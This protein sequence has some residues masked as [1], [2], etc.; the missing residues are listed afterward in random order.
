MSTKDGPLLLSLASLALGACAPEILPATGAQRQE[1]FHSEI[2]DDDYVLRIRTP[3]DMEADPGATH[4]LVVQLDP[5]YAGL[6]EHEI[7]VGLVSQHAADG[8]WPEA[9]VVGVD[10]PDP[11]TRERDY[12]PETPPDPEFEGE[13]A[14]RFHRVLQD[15]ILPHLE[16]TLPID[17]TRRILVGH[18]NGAVF[19]WYAAF[20]H[21]PGE[22]PLFSGIVAADAGID[23]V[24]FTFERWH[25]ERSD[26][27]PIR[28]YA[29]RAVYNGAV[30]KIAFDA[31]VERIEDR[32]YEGLRLVTEALETDHGGAIEP[33]FEQGLEHAL[34]GEP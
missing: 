5:T 7:T 31:L 2:V 17:P 28:M 21:D 26:A 19:G 29:S 24:L 13:G 10:Y 3:P 12:R 14:D 32:D 4:P 27:L 22:P 16:D 23:E 30:Q 1:T 18:S 9:I 8:R 25:A 34:V 20:R 15:E 6:R 33:S 11:S